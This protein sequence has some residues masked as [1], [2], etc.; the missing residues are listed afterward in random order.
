MDQLISEH[1]ALMRHC[2]QIQTRCSNLVQAQAITIHQLSAQVMRLRAAVIVRDTTLAWAREDRAELEATMPG[3]P[4]RVSLSRHVDTLLARIQDLMRERFHWQQGGLAKRV[5]ASD[6]F[7]P[8]V[9]ASALGSPEDVAP[10]DDLA[11]LEN[12]L[13][14]ADLVICQTGCLSHGAYW[15]VQDHCKRTG[16]TCVLVEQPDVVRIVHIH[17]PLTR[18]TAADAASSLDMAPS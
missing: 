17:N 18:E 5:A 13:V 6:D 12:S 14:A 2:G 1:H 15:R 10:V 4:R 16:K 9:R 3:L 8:P 11:S 7:P